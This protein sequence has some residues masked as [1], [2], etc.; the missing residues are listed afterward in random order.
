MRA[1]AWSPWEVMNEYGRPDV[2]LHFWSLA[3]VLLLMLVPETSRPQM[4]MPLRLNLVINDSQDMM[5]SGNWSLLSS[6]RFRA[7]LVAVLRWLMLSEL[8]VFTMTTERCNRHS[9]GRMKW[10][11]MWKDYHVRGGGHW[12][13]EEDQ[14]QILAEHPWTGSKTSRLFLVTFQECVQNWR[15]VQQDETIC[16]WPECLYH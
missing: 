3:E 12:K 8:V 1:E 13:R 4:S 5:L 11:S 9:S 7:D 15:K 10:V 16:C 2:L 14:A 6:F